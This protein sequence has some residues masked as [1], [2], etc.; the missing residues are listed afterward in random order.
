MPTIRDVDINQR[1]SF[2]VYPTSV[3]GHNFRDVRLEGRISAQMALNF[4]LD[5]EA[6]HQAVYPSLPAGTPNDPFTFDYIRIQ[7]PNGAYDILAVQWIRQETIQISQGGQVT[8]VFENRTQLEVDRML[9]A[10]SANGFRPDD[11]QV[12]A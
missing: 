8:M 11:V 7:H 12:R 4:G 3:I 10:L 1:F 6:M 5:I 9:N 2:E